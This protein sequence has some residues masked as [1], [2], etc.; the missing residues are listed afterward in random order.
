[1]ST[2]VGS[3]SQLHPKCRLA[4]KPIKNYLPKLGKKWF[5]Q[6]DLYCVFCGRKG[7]DR[8]S[9]PA[10]P[11]TPKEEDR[12]PFVEAIL[13]LPRVQSNR[14][15]GMTPTEALTWVEAQGAIWNKSNPWADSTL[16]YDKLR[17]RLGH[18]RAIGASDSVISWLGYGVPMRFV[19]EP[20]YHA[21]PNHKMD[22]E[23]EAYMAKDMSKHQ[24]DGC[25][26]EAPAF[27][28]RVANPILV[29]D[30]NGKYRRCDDCR[31]GNSMQASPKFKMC[32][33]GQDVPTLANP[34]DIAITEDLEKAYYKVPLAK[35]ARPYSAFQWGSVFFFS[36]VMLFG[37]CQAP[38]FF[39][40]IC[41]PIARLFGALKIPALNYIDDWFWSAKPENAGPLHTFIRDLFAILGWSFN[42]KSQKG[43]RVQFLGFIIDMV[44]R[45][46]V[47]PEAKRTAILDLLR[48]HRLAASAGAIVSARAMQ[49][50]LGKVISVTLAVPSVRVWCRSLY[51]QVHDAVGNRRQNSYMTLSPESILELG[52]LATLLTLTDGSPFISPLHDVDIWCD[53]GE[54]GWGAH[55]LG[56]VV[57]GQFEA[58]EIG[59][60]STFR[61]LR[62]L[63]LVL[64][65]LAPRIKGKVVR[66]NMDSMCSVRN[67]MKGGGP[68]PVLCDLV[69]DVWLESTMHDFKLFPRWQRRSEIDM[70]KADDLSKVGTL[71]K[72]RASFHTW[73][74]QKYGVPVTMPDVAKAKQAI[75]KTVSAGIRH[76]LVL[77][78]WEA[79]PW[80]ALAS[81][82]ALA[83]L[84]LPDMAIVVNP[85]MYDIPR[86]DFVLCIF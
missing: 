12:V 84:P 11:T 53:A 78:R 15:I 79:K 6:A 82:H 51:R 19:R 41:K 64:R 52:M 28:V 2:H 34:G 45:K 8:N 20:T 29:I 14:F 44:G 59:T 83:T 73:V 76:A 32:S 35:D 81:S 33:V 37:M 9:C 31:Y 54:V 77:P 27:S 86:W 16:V 70:Q 58:H 63:V 43:T 49:R 26:V 47:V 30:Q 40:G 5:K 74:W 80:W 24:E 56:I 22:A 21:F 10:R 17:A 48:D 39:T 75:V 62:G 3:R 42:D 68:N 65:A 72:L 1:M 25:F 46:F 23:G 69:K 61:E 71:W 67:L 57:H 4:T 66:L 7:H 55:M 38:F 36:M 60:S 13:A 50:T 85:N 18:W